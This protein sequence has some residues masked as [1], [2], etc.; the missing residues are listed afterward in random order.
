MKP[1]KKFDLEEL[2]EEQKADPRYIYLAA[3]Y[4][5]ADPLIV[6]ARVEV[7]NQVA[8]ELMGRGLYVFSPISHCHPIARAVGLPGSFAY[9]QGYNRVMLC[10]A[11]AIV[12]LTLE[13]WTVSTGVTGELEI[14][15]TIGIPG[16]QLSILDA[17]DLDLT[18]HKIA[19]D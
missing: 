2:L 15:D 7:I 4:S 17:L 1:L 18:G 9:W 6:D 3:P 12:V 11:L 8:G 14:A 10:G 5:H 16:Y 19:F 13:G